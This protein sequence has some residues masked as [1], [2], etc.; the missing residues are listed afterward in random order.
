MEHPLIS[1]RINLK[2][3]IDLNLDSI[4]SDSKAAANSLKLGLKKSSVGI[5]KNKLPPIE[6]KPSAIKS[7]QQITRQP[8]LRLQN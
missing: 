7:W 8:S 4:D 2:P 3:K 1:R 5:K 6:K